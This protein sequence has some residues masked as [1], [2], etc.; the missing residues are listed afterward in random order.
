MKKFR[1]CK[2]IVK[3][4]ADKR[5][6]LRACKHLHDFSVMFDKNK[7]ITEVV[8]EF[9]KDMTTI[10][11]KGQI[12]RIRSKGRLRHI[13]KNECGLGLDLDEYQFVN[14]LAHLWDCDDKKD[15]DKFIK[16]RK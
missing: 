11:E 3:S 7:R 6:F 5:E 12:R 2:I 4:E 15:R 16:V 9:G 10:N 1:N 13:T 8:D 14:F